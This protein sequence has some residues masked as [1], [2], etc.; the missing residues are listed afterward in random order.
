MTTVFEEG[1]EMLIDEAVNL[2][3]KR[4]FTP[5][6]MPRLIRLDSSAPLDGVSR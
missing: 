4:T 3:S 1:N 2:S 5:N 6:A